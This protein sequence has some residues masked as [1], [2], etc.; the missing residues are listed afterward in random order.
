[1]AWLCNWKEVPSQSCATPGFR[2][3]SLNCY[4]T[5]VLGMWRLHLQCLRSSFTTVVLDSSI[6]CSTNIFKCERCVLNLQWGQASLHL[7]S[8]CT[9]KFMLT[10]YT[11]LPRQALQ[12]AYKQHWRWVKHVK[13]QHKIH[14]LTPPHQGLLCNRYI[15]T[16]A[17][18]SLTR[19]QHV[20]WQN[21]LSNIVT[22]NTT[23]IESQ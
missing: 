23:K 2:A 6:I 19:A 16:G 15:F 22:Q 4:K 21:T 7:D 13:Y 18:S 11:K 17:L 8:S 14:Y 10:E 20:E 12:Q 3:E 5:R 1:M 9:L